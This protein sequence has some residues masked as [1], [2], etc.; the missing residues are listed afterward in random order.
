M[1]Y[2]KQIPEAFQLSPDSQDFI[3]VLDG[4]QQ[5]KDGIIFKST[6]I[7][8]P[9]LLTNRGFMRKFLKEFGWPDIPED[10]PKK[11][12]DNMYLNAEHVFRLQGSKIGLEY[13]LR[14][15][16]CGSITIDDQD[17]FPKSSYIILDDLDYGYL[18]TE[19]D[20]PKNILYL[21]DGEDSFLPRFLTIG[22]KTPYWYLQSLKDYI[23]TNIYRFIGFTDANTTLTITF[24]EG[25]FVKNILANPYFEDESV[26]PLPIQLQ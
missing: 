18:F 15:L 5:Y 3:K 12:L 2:S 24:E 23:N 17:F 6:R 22:I 10:F 8:N 1:L 11:I 4:L 25:D 7:Y 14:V 19:T 16:T 26:L 13:L 21:Y 20:Y 9:V